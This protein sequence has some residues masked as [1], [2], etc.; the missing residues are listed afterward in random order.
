MEASA[1]ATAYNQ[2]SDTPVAV[3]EQPPEILPRPG[4]APLLRRAK[5]IGKLYISNQT[6]LCMRWEDYPVFVDLASGVIYDKLPRFY[7]PNDPV[8]PLEFASWQLRFSGPE[9]LI[10]EF[11][12]ID[13]S[14]DSVSV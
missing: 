7:G 11:S 8:T 1:G 13:L 14:E 3:F 10:Y 9:A 5:D 6:F 4:V 12:R 2:I